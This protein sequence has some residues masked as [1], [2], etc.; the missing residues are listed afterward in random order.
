[1][2]NKLLELCEGFDRF[3]LKMNA[4]VV[5]ICQLK[6]EGVD[7]S[8]REGS[9]D[10]PA[11]VHGGF[12]RVIVT[13]T[14]REIAQIDFHPRLPYIKRVALDT[15]HYWGSVKIFLKFTRPFWSEPNKLPIIYYNKTK[16]TAN[17]GVAVSD[18]PLRQVLIHPIHMVDEF[19]RLIIRQ[20][21]FMD[22]PSWR[23]T[24]GRLKLTFG[25]LCLMRSAFRG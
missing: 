4:R 1:M 14:S 18:D 17:G 24:T 11:E 5:G 20:I 7:V 10:S 21:L 23:V 25:C 15:L 16:L 3:K 8:V 12:D 22:L 9:S 6:E 13:A 2:T 19:F